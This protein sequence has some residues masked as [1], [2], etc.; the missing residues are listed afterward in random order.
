M[1]MRVVM[2]MSWRMAL[3]SAGEQ[4]AP[5]WHFSEFLPE[6]SS[7]SRSGADLSLFS[8]LLSSRTFNYSRPSPSSICSL[9]SSII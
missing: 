8:M 7:P 5:K 9:S 4:G 6:F 3:A 1:P 2:L